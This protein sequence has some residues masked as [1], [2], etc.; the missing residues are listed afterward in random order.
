M[1]SITERNP[2]A[3]SPH[4]RIDARQEEAPRDAVG[5]RPRLRS[6]RFPFTDPDATARPARTAGRK[7]ID[8][9]SAAGELVDYLTS[10]H[11]I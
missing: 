4:S 11:L 5:I 7:V 1:I 6:A 10:S 2:E 9:G 3:G 8:D